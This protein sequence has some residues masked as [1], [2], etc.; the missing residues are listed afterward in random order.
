MLHAH[1]ALVLA[2][3]VAKAVGILQERYTINTLE[4]IPA[5]PLALM[6]S[7]FLPPYL[8]FANLVLRSAS[9][10]SIALKSVLI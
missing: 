7:S 6:D 5:T 9:R 8:I 4:L 10:V 2:K 1:L 3:I